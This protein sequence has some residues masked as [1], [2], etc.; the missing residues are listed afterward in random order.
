[1]FPPTVADYYRVALDGVR[2][3]VSNTPDDRALSLNPDEWC[4]YFI[5]KYEMEP[6]TAD[7]GAIAMEETT[8][9][10]GHPAILVTVPVEPSDTFD[11]IAKEGLAGHG[12]WLGFDY[13][14][15]FS[16]RRRYTIGQV[17]LPEPN[18]INAAKRRIAE[19]VQ[20]LNNAIEQEN[21]TFP[22]QVRDVVK[23]RVDSIRAKDKRLEDLSTSVGIP[24]V[25]RAEVSTVVPTAVKVKKTIQ[26][27]VPP[28]SRGKQRP[29]LE[30]D[31]FN[32][33]M[34]LIDNQC[35]AFERTPTVYQAMS[36]EALRDIILGAL[37]AV[38]AGAATGEAF[39]VLGKTDIHLQISRG[40][41][42]IAEAKVW[43]GPASL[44]E[45]VAQLLDRLTWRDG[46]GVA[47]LFSQNADFGEVLKTVEKHLP[48]LTRAV[49]GTMTKAGVNHYVMRFV[50]PSDA[51]THVEIHVVAYNLFTPRPSGR[52]S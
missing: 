48:G 1:M 19:Y 40:E 32:S 44:A 15:F 45:V 14:T 23:A 52:I 4:D 17:E 20:S 25:R 8:F 49:P 5:D 29:V 51:S 47:I 6:I 18:H 39:S 37:N 42:F 16:D 46:F 3:E 12:G 10:N 7:I 50:L 21:K 11:V 35:R 43:S 41:L 22:D 27:V 36:E 34:E 31:K 24:L 2:K 28:Q 30:R 38:F 26:P 13:R 33:I 9:N